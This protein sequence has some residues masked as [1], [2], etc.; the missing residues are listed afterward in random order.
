MGDDGIGGQGRVVA[1]RGPDV[2]DGRNHRDL[3][4]PL[5]LVDL[6]IEGVGGGDGAAGAVDPDD[7]RLDAVVLLG[8]A[9]LL[10]HAREDRDARRR[11]GEGKARRVIGEDAG[12]VEQQDLLRALAQDGV[13]LEGADPRLEVNGEHGAAGKKERRQQTEKPGTPHERSIRARSWTDKRLRPARPPR[14][15]Y[16]GAHVA[17]A[18]GRAHHRSLPGRLWTGREAPSEFRR[19]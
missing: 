15:N 14:V 1:T 11:R 17:S 16:N 4:P 13:L 3:L 5:E 19:M 18:P 10:L 7:E 9:Q 2:H 12:E 8:L 6:A